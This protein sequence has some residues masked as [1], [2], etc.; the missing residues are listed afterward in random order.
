[1]NKRMTIMVSALGIVFG[2]IIGFNL[3]KGFMI[4]RFFCVL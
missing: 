1:M 3:F 4:K 2:G